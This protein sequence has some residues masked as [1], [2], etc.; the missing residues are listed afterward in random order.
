MKSIL[1]ILGPK[2]DIIN[3]LDTDYELV[4][5]C[6][7]AVKIID[8]N[9]ATLDLYDAETKSELIEN[10]SQVLVIESVEEF[11]KEL[12]ALISGQTSYQC[13]IY[14]KKLS[15][16][17]IYGWLRLSVPPGYEDNWERVHI[18]IVD[19]TERKKAEEKLRFMSFHDALTGLYNRAYFEEEMD[20]LRRGRQFPISIIACDLDGLKQI[21]DQLGH[22]AGDRAIKSAAK[23][24]S[25]HTFRKEDVVAR[26]GGDEFVVILPAVNLDENKTI[27]ER[28]NNGI[29][30]FNSSTIDDDHFRPV[31]F[32]LGYAVVHEGGSLEEG[33]KAADTA[34][35]INKQ[36]KKD[37][38]P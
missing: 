20:R 31:S 22:D 3:R 4:N 35:Y 34:M 27:L 1:E 15:G 30:L 10:L 25:M 21:N 16:E 13:E 7:R 33:Y 38:N 2:E 23:I 5:E 37:P 19:I 17:L 11:R 28:M 26:I 29:E 24:L 18:S 12:I 6:I 32:S 8:I 36:K 14:Q 9:Q